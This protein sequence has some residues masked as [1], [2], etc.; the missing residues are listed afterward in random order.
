MEGAEVHQPDQQGGV[1]DGVGDGDN[2]GDD[3]GGWGG[4]V[5]DNIGK[6][7]RRTKKLTQ[8]DEVGEKMVPGGTQGEGGVEEVG[9]VDE[10]DSQ[11]TTR[12]H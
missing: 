1:D 2:Y 12:A 8:E 4:G 10:D 7:G 11:V 3:A 5:N 6:I 9:P